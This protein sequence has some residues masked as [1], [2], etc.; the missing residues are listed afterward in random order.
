MSAYAAI[1]SATSAAGCSPRVA[2]SGLLRCS[3]LCQFAGWLARAVNA[4]RGWSFYLKDGKLLYVH[5]Y[6]RR[7]LY[8]VS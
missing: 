1:S 2:A 4:A 5:N 3:Y 7:A 6:V 8:H